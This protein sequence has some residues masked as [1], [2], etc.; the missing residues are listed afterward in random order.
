MAGRLGRMARCGLRGGGRSH[1]LLGFRLRVERLG[2]SRFGPRQRGECGSVY[3]A[4]CTGEAGRAAVLDSAA[5]AVVPLVGRVVA[6]AEPPAP[7]AASGALPA[8]DH[9]A[10]HSAL[11]SSSSQSS[12]S[13]PGEWPAAGDGLSHASAAAAAGA[14][15]AVAEPDAP[16]SGSS[17][18]GRGVA[19]SHDSMSGSRSSGSVWD[20]TGNPAVP[21]LR[22]LRCRRPAQSRGRSRRLCRWWP[23]QPTL[24][25]RT[26][27]VSYTHL[28]VYKRQGVRM[29]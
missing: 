14:C 18:E 25:R 29:P 11:S 12:T 20:A 8:S 9:W 19:A 24:R 22:P 7:V 21:V 5:A 16:A 13:P 2:R 23:R 26:R 4:W 15:P 3:S 10:S 17:A 28:D 1:P 27:R 6:A